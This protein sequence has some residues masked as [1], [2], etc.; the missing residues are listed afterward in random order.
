[1]TGVRRF[2]KM[3]PADRRTLVF[4]RLGRLGRNAWWR[5]RDRRKPTYA[6]D[7]ATL[8]TPARILPAASREELEPHRERLRDY[9]AR[10]AGVFSR[11]PRSA[12]V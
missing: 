12:M 3:K 6:L 1:M 2:L 5:V 9:A 7:R 10:C 11:N 8:G 4:H